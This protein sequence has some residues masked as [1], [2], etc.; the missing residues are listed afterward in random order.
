MSVKFGEK[1][2]KG[3]FYF[4]RQPVSPSG[5]SRFPGGTAKHV[6]R[7]STFAQNFPFVAHPSPDRSMALVKF[8]AAM[9]ANKGFAREFLN[10]SPWEYSSPP[11]VHHPLNPVSFVLLDFISPNQRP[12]RYQPYDKPK[13]STNTK[14]PRGEGS[15]AVD[16]S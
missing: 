1:Q 11:F 5:R 8:T 2:G 4:L 12:S 9:A 7:P 6:F 13:T 10:P 14:H 15:R 16:F 3:K